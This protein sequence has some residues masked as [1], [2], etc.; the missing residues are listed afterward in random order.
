MVFELG[1]DGFSDDI[2]EF[3]DRERV[4]ILSAQEAGIHLFLDR[5]RIPE[6]VDGH[7]I[8]LLSQAGHATDPLFQP[9]WIPWD[10]DI[11]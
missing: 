3:A 7:L 1:E 8:G 2:R 11:D 10:I 4:K 5:P 9:G 6:I